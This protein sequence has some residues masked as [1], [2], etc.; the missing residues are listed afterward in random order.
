M[1][2]NLTTFKGT[3]SP[4]V[5]L[6]ISE[7]LASNKQK[8]SNVLDRVNTLE[9]RTTGDFE[10]SGN[11]KVDGSVLTK[12]KYLTKPSGERQEVICSACTYEGSNYLPSTNPAWNARKRNTPSIPVTRDGGAKQFIKE[13]VEVFNSVSGPPTGLLQQTLQGVCDQDY[14]YYFGEIGDIPYVTGGV[15]VS[16]WTYYLGHSFVSNTSVIIKQ[17]RTTG[18]VVQARL[19]GEMVNTYYYGAP[20][21]SGV[22]NIPDGSANYIT[23]DSSTYEGTGDDVTRG[24]GAIYDGH[25]YTT[26]QS[27]KY[28]SM[29]KIRCSDLSLVWRYEV[30]STDY[31]PVE[32]DP[33]L[34]AAGIIMRQI[35]VIPPSESRPHPTVITT[36]T[37]AFQYSAIDADTLLKN[38]QY[39]TQGGHVWAWDDLGTTAQYRWDFTNSPRPFVA[40]DVLPNTVFKRD[41]SGAIIDDLEIYYPLTNGYEFLDVAADGSKTSGTFNLLTGNITID[42]EDYEFAKFT[43]ADG[44]VLSESDYY[45]GIVQIGE[46]QGNEVTVSGAT[47]LSPTTYYGNPTTGMQSVVKVLHASTQ[48]GVKVLDQYE[49]SELSSYGG[50]MYNAIVYDAERDVVMFPV[51]NTTHV[52]HDY[53]KTTFQAYYEFNVDDSGNQLTNDP[54]I[55]ENPVYLGMHRYLNL[56]MMNGSYADYDQGTDSETALNIQYWQQRY[57]NTNKRVRESVNLGDYNRRQMF[58]GFVG[59]NAST[60]ELLFGLRTTGGVDNVDHTITFFNYWS[61]NSIFHPNGMNEDGNTISL[62]RSKPTHFDGNGN[63]TAWNI[64]DSNGNPGAWL[65]C[66]TKSRTY[67]FDY[68]QLFNKITHIPG[69]NSLGYVKGIASNTAFEDAILYEEMNAVVNGVIHFNGNACNGPTL[70]SRF[71][72]NSS[73]APE[74]FADLSGNS[75]NPD[76]YIVDPAGKDDMASN[77]LIAYDLKHIAAH[78]PNTVSRSRAIKW[79]TG[80]EIIGVHDTGST[81]MYGDIALL[82]SKNGELKLIDVNTGI[83]IDTVINNE[84]MSTVPIVADGIMYGYGGT[85]KWSGPGSVI[86]ATKIN[87]WTPNGK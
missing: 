53:E 83:T 71:T 67:I 82:G 10:V 11:L 74:T 42:N 63:P 70:L 44:V 30:S 40:G 34:T 66:T 72:G 47:L 48:V 51:S 19:L 87:M 86:H 32:E 24:P 59:L 64:V 35:L 31:R 54:Y 61:Q 73:S 21:A 56:S 22:Y 85:T 16:L 55:L 8:I 81:F 12:T 79:I 57:W 77:I 9:H 46:N 1:S 76:G 6:Y 58:S 36:S 25:L 68:N 41:S 52:C 3:S 45:T 80:S 60:G 69:D 4:H 2:N 78:P 43:F 26:G 5:S 13:P 39:Y 62:V 7:Q 75:L 20:D 23:T 14:V 17:S 38:F 29:F 27:V 49:A 15:D 33:L 37:D 65:G 28:A 18:Q 50:G 84:G